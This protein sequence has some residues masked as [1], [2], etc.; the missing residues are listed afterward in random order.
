M[1]SVVIVGEVVVVIVVG[2]KEVVVAGKAL[3]VSKSVA[4]NLWLARPW[5]FLVRVSLMA[6]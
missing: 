6:A 5:S 2:G 3:G 1:V 4:G